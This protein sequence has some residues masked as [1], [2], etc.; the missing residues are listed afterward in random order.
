MGVLPGVLDT[1]E[2]IELPPEPP[3]LPRTDGSSDE[4]RARASGVSADTG[5]ASG[6]RGAAVAPVL[7]PEHHTMIRVGG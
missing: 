4:S 3:A 5:E 2:D 1:R 7:E 6:E